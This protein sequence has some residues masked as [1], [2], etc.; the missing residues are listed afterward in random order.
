MKNNPFNKKKFP[1]CHTG[2]NYALDIL[3]GKIVANKW[4]KG[5]CQRYIDDLKRIEEDKDCPFYFRPEQ[6]EKFLRLV[7]KFYHVKGKWDT[8]EI[9]YIPCQKFWFL[10]QFFG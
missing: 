3:S 7:Q 8:K 9:I 6:A 10:C 5:S 2:H 1:N 4:V